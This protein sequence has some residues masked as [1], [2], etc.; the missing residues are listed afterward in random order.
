MGE[1]ILTIYLV[2][3]PVA[4]MDNLTWET[5]NLFGVNVSADLNE[6]GDKVEASYKCKL[7]SI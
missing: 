4:V 5:C 3:Q 6:S 1:F 7:K 2:L